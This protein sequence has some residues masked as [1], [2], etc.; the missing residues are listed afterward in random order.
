MDHSW[1]SMDDTALVVAVGRFQEQALAEVYRRHGGSAYALASR[2]LRDDARAEEVTQDVFLRLWEQPE[3]FDPS[4]GS[5]RSYLLVQAHRRAVDLLRQDTARTERHA[6]AAQM[7]AAPGY[8]LEDEIWDLTV[9]E[10]V[11][12]AFASLP[13]GERNAIELAYFGGHTYREVASILA[14]PEGT[15]KSRIRS[16]LRRLQGPLLALSGEVVR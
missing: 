2:V 8:S 13:D 12:E 10:R 16:G 9:S 11:K 5:L 15:I 3:R 7:E 14:E 4:R 6:R 1:Q